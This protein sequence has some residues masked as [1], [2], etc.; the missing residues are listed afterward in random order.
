MKTIVLLS[1]VITLMIGSCTDN[2]RKSLQGTWQ[3]VQMQRVDGTKVTNYFSERY[4][5]SQI[6]MWSGNHFMFVGKYEVDTTL[7]YRYG[8]GTYTLNGNLYE[9]DILYH[10]SKSY[11]GHKNKIWL[12]IRNDTLFHA[13]PVDD[14]GKPTQTTH[15]IEKYV[16]L[17]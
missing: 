15:W 4:K 7:N 8:V 11:E 3:M 17:N 2:E 9:E 1:L 12:E 6:K 13:F 5:V 16:R 10:F 14:T